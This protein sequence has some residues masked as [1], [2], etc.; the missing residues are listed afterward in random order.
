MFTKIA[1][2]IIYLRAHYEE[3]KGHNVKLQ[4]L[5]RTW[6]SWMVVI[7]AEGL[8]FQTEETKFEY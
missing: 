1:F 2:K 8:V 5:E 6:S 7:M 4:A 3:K